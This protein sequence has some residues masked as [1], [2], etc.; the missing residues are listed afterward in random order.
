MAGPVS[1]PDAVSR[2]NGLPAGGRADSAVKELP[3]FDAKELLAVPS[4]LGR[5]FLLSFVPIR[6][7]ISLARGYG[8]LAARLWARPA[9]TQ[10]DI[11]LVAGGRFTAKERRRI[12]M[13]HVQ[14]RT[15]R[16]VMHYCQD[17]RVLTPEVSGL[18]YLDA[19]LTGGRGAL[20]VGPHF[21]YYEFAERGLQQLGYPCRAVVSVGFR[22]KGRKSKLGEFIY[23]KLLRLPETY[24]GT[25]RDIVAS[26]GALP[27]LRAL[28]RN[29]VVF[30]TADFPMPDNVKIEV[31][32]VHLQVAAGPARLSRMSGA[33]ILTGFFAPSG[34]G[35]RIEALIGAPL[36]LPDNGD[37]QAA[38]DEYGRRY[39]DAILRF[40][41]AMR[42]KILRNAKKRTGGT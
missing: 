35:G 3:L 33:P 36:P 8:W 14:F 19:A 26:D 34:D 2:R 7:Q 6:W 25:D 20:I 29:E 31:L 32:G 42:W 21:G 12:A 37:P 11:E 27:I 28:R 16:H 40:P 10:R 4:W 39:A 41:H 5:R 24:R 17:Y 9:R 15:E 18:E 22:R 30:I 13:S 1:S 23:Q 38:Y